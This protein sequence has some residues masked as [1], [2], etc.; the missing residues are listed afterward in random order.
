MDTKRISQVLGILLSNAVKFTGLGGQV[1]VLLEFDAMARPR[2]NFLWPRAES[3]WFNSASKVGDRSSRRAYA[4][5]PGGLFAYI[6]V[7]DTGCGIEKV[8]YE[9]VLSYSILLF[10]SNNVSEIYS[11]YCTVPSS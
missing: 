11:L 9:L 7:T 5:V 4:D 1:S 8:Q 2:S 10:S 3:G 6:K